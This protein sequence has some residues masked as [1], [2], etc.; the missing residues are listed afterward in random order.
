[1]IHEHG[2][3]PTVRA[4]FTP[5]QE[6][7]LVLSRRE[8]L[9]T[10]AE[11]DEAAAFRDTSLEAGR[12]RHAWGANLCAQ[13]GRRELGRPSMALLLAL[14]T[15]CDETAVAILR[16]VE[17]LASEVASQIA[18]HE[19]FGGVVPEVASRN[20]L[21]MLRPVIGRALKTVAWRSPKSMRLPRRAGPV[22]PLRR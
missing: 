13:D 19:A 15:S 18:I 7:L 22:S 14:E 2:V 6:R 16:G 20:H 17:L 21:R 12:R 5:E 9:S 10:D 11:K 8:D 3:T 1:M 4:T